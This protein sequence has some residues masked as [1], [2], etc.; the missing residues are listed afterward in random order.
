[1][2]ICNHPDLYD[3]GPKHFGE[4]DYAHLEP[5]QKYGFWRRSGKMIVIEA[6]LKLWKR[7]GHRVLLFTQS[8][9]MLTILERFACEKVI[10]RNSC[11]G[12]KYLFLL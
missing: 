9:Q 10:V 11:I 12:V 3:G 5:E 1:M 2:K 7:Q 8:R 4:V 6:L